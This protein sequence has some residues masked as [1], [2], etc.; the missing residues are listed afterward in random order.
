MLTAVKKIII[1]VLILAVAAAA[2]FLLFLQD[3]EDGGLVQ[4]VIGNVRDTVVGGFDDLV[5]NNTSGNNNGAGGS[6]SGT[7]APSLRPR[8]T[9]NEEGERVYTASGWEGNTF[10][11][12]RGQFSFTIPTGWVQM[13]PGQYNQLFDRP[14]STMY[15]G[16]VDSAN[17]PHTQIGMAR[18]NLRSALVRITN[19]HDRVMNQFNHDAQISIHNIPTFLNPVNIAEHTW[20]HFRVARGGTAQ[21]YFGTYL[22]GH[23]YIMW[24]YYDEAY[25]IEHVLDMFGTLEDSGQHRS[26][27]QNRTRPNLQETIYVPIPYQLPDQMPLRILGMA[28]VHI[29]IDFQLE[30]REGIHPDGLQIPA[31][32]AFST[33]IA[34]QVDGYWIWDLTAD[35]VETLEV[36]SFIRDGRTMVPVRVI[37]EI[38]GAEVGWN[39]ETQ[40][41][42]LAINDRQ[43]YS[44][45]VSLRLDELNPDHYDYGLDV[46]ATRVGGTTFVPLRFVSEFLGAEIHW[47]GSPYRQIDIIR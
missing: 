36:A 4:D 14:Q 9:L 29:P 39:G 19:T 28:P 30:I 13:T 8:Y 5:G 10:Y 26:P 21:H 22:E 18:I 35:Y 32:N 38:L 3:S 40:T 27:N 11:S 46:P 45:E 24:V 1:I 43:G 44:R 23:M 17:N 20:Y 12:Y 33:H 25:P 7:S 2:V 31:R 15:L 37:A 34:L 47:I 16:T 42:T 6:G 41:V